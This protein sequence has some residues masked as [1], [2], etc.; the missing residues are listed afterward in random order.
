MHVCVRRMHACVCVLRL[1]CCVQHTYLVLW[2]SASCSVFVG[3]P[4]VWRAAGAHAVST[5]WDLDSTA[6]VSIFMAV[7]RRRRILVVKGPADLQSLQPVGRDPS[8][9]CH[10]GRCTRPSGSGSIGRSVGGRRAA[11]ADRGAA[12]D[13]KV[14]EVLKLQNKN[15]I[16]ACK[17]K[18]KVFKD[19]LA[20]LDLA[21][22]EILALQ[23]D[24]D[25][26]TR[27]ILSKPL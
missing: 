15:Q 7:C 17:S 8:S 18:L 4:N 5:M 21:N 24:E 3:A 27:V 2:S 22:A 25:V 12:A 23:R 20:E 14:L 26:L 19:T 11:V 6:A 10:G 9:V 16:Q 13:S 1:H